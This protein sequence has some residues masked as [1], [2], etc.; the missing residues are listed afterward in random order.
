MIHSN[1]LQTTDEEIPIRSI[2]DLSVYLARAVESRKQLALANKDP[3]LRFKSH[4]VIKFSL[5]KIINSDYHLLS[6]LIF[7]DTA[8]FEFYSKN[9]ENN[10]RKTETS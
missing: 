9:P 8:G 1:M 3:K 7:L 4:F 5:H 10:I 2:E 6:S